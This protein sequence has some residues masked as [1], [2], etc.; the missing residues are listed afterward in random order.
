MTHSIAPIVPGQHGPFIR[1]RIPGWPRHLHEGDLAHLG[2]ALGVPF[3]HQAWFVRAAAEHR[4]ALRD[5][6][7]RRTRAAARHARSLAGLKGLGAFC[8]P[9]LQRALRLHLGEEIDVSTCEL[10]EVRKESGLIG[11]VYTVQSLLQAALHNFAADTRFGTLSGVAPADAFGVEFIPRGRRLP[12]VRFSYQRKLGIEPAAFAQLCHNLDLGGQYQAHLAQVLEGEHKASIRDHATALWQSELHVALQ[13]AFMKQDISADGW[14][15]L[16]ALADGSTTL[17]LHASPMQVCRLRMFQAE[18]ADVL[19]VAPASER[20]IDAPVILW[21]PGA[22]LCPLKEYPS[23]RVAVEAL[24]IN[25]CQPGYREAWRRYVD[26]ADQ[27]HVFARLEGALYR[28]VADAN[29]LYERVPDRDAN[30]YLTQE[31]VAGELFDTLHEAQ[32]QRLKRQARYLAVPSADADEQARKA[33]LDHWFAIGFN[34]LNAAAFVVPGLGVVM[35]VVTAVQLCSEVVTGI[36]DWEHGDMAEAWAHFQS[37]AVNLALVAGMGVAARPVKPSAVVDGLMRV[38]LP[39]GESRLWRPVLEGY[40]S[41]VDLAGEVPDGEGLYYRHGQPFVR[42]ERRFYGLEHDGSGQWRVRHPQDEQA[43]RPL[44]RHNGQG[45]C[46]IE[47][48]QP[49]YWER[50]Q[51]LERIGPLAD[52]LDRVHV[53]DALRI[54]GVG[55]HALRLALMERQPLPPLLRETLRRMQVQLGGASGGVGDVVTPLPAAARRLQREFPLLCDEVVLELAEETGGDVHEHGVLVAGQIP[56]RLAEEARLYQRQV[57]LNRALEA[58]SGV[59]PATLDGDRLGLALLDRLPGWPDDLQVE[60]YD[61][62]VRET[63]VCASGAGKASLRIIREANGYTMLD[64]QGALQ[65]H[66]SLAEAL[67]AGLG[68]HRCQALDLDPANPGS[69]LRQLFDLATQD[70]ARAARLIGLQPARPWFRP[71]LRLADGRLG[72]TLGGSAGTLSGGSRRLGELYPEMNSTQIQQLKARLLLGNASL[73]AAISALENEFSALVEA[74]QAWALEETLSVS[75]RLRRRTVSQRLRSAWRRLGAEQGRHLDLS[76]LGVG[77][78]PD[79]AANFAHVRILNLSRMELAQVPEGFLAGFPRLQVLNLNGNQLL[80]IPA[81]VRRLNGLRNLDLEGNV[82]QQAAALLEPVRPLAH[83]N[84]LNLG[85]NGLN[86]L[87]QEALAALRGFGRLQRLYLRHNNLST[88][89]ALMDTLASLPL[90]I[91]DLSGNQMVLDGAAALTFNRMTRLRHLALS[92][93]PLGR[94][95]LLGGMEQLQFL[96]MQ[97]CSLNRWPDSLSYLMYR[98]P[99]ALRGVELSYNRIAEIPELEST[100]FASLIRQDRHGSH[101]LH[102]DRNPLTPLS[103]ERLQAIGQH[104]FLNDD[105]AAST[106]WLEGMSAAQRGNWVNLFGD[107]RHVPLLEMLERLGASREFERNPNGLRARVWALLELAGGHANLREELVEIAESYPVTCGDAG[108]DAFSDLEIAALAFRRSLEAATENAR[109]SAL[110]GLYKQLF[111]RAEVQRLA[112]GLSLRRTQRQRALYEQLPAPPL[113]PLDTISDADLRSFMVDDIEIRLALRQSLA[114][115]LDFPE[116]SQGMLFRPLARISR[117]TIRRVRQ[118]VLANETPA[119]REQWMVRDP[120]WKRYLRKRYADQFRIVADFW[121]EGV[122]YLDDCVGI[123]DDP[124]DRLDRSIVD[125]L[126]EAL[127]QSPLDVHGRTRKLQLDDWQYL[128]ASNALRQ[129]HEQAEAQLLLNLTRAEVLVA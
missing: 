83:L 97:A 128:Q 122:A 93:N 40:A 34:L 104:Y 127:D 77:R 111:R 41:E 10:V 46:W 4:Q 65:R 112:D 101:W 20:D 71:P 22:P 86:L 43:Y 120:S 45:S 29:G 109:G 115:H 28:L 53:D 110:V 52:G 48:E 79:L 70:R 100:R 24:R 33:R 3:E 108:A 129:A 11:P 63:A 64:A 85:G 51:L 96:D 68:A 32:M 81:C 1:A 72:Y 73:D 57:R 7:R 6:C 5:A 23:Y 13:I 16:L 14:R 126:T 69:L 61:L 31:E 74:L 91:L 39:N 44:L 37:V 21:L 75:G 49:R 90:E 27:A 18:L 124:V 25:L 89:E 107:R 117:T 105:Q 35:A 123:G 121:G 78:L 54:S 102:L 82:L 55:E 66:P 116:P 87:P 76:G 59:F 50:A 119:N 95:P 92:H 19:L 103:I 80:A 47:G 99:C 113:D 88:S 84:S 38:R 8:E 56:L 15:L 17:H 36:R 42:I 106:V 62:A 114:E 2:H 118:A 94:A 9:L 67:L 98:S 58:L 30:L 26:H 60:L 12:G 125:T